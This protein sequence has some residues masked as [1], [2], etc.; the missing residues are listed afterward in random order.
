M[1]IITDIFA[2]C[3]R[4]HP[5]AGTRSRSPATTSARPARRRCRRSPSRSPTRIAYVQAAIDA[6]LDVDE[7][8]PA[9][10]VLLERAQQLLRGGRQ[11]PRR[12]AHVAPDHDR[13][14]RRQEASRASCC[15]STPRPAARRS[16]RSSPRTTSCGSRV[17]ALAAVL[18]GTQ[19][20]HTNGYDEALGLPTERGGPH[21][22]AHAADH[23]L[24]ARRRR[25]ARSA[26]RLVLRRVA[27]R[28]GRAAGVGVHR[29]H[30][31]DGRRGG[32]DRGRL[33][34]GRDRAGRLRVHEV[35]RR[36][37]AGDRRASTSSR[38]TTSPSPTCSRSTRRSR[39]GQRRA[40]R[41]RSRPTATRPTVEAAP[42]RRPGRGARAREN[43]LLPDE[44]RAARPTPRSARSATPCATCSASTTPAA[45][46]A[47]ADRLAPRP[48]SVSNDAFG[49]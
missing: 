19:S 43:L 26:G 13:A 38:S 33:P 23:R 27:D 5:A 14:L 10:V 8:A 20:L 18:G 1:R 37:R 21:R 40:A 3:A 9:A 44:G 42:R 39:R 46:P 2:Y 7:F 31:R 29:A 4:A 34:D 16:P 11:V 35:D 41:A 45:E 47:A 24:R 48:G 28:R 49:L 32:G 12:P 30:R 15:A 36:R 6:G 22:A 17:Q 25:H